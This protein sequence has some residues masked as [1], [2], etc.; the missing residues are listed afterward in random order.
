VEETREGAREEGIS[1]CGLAMEKSNIVVADSEVDMAGGD[2]GLLVVAGGIA[3]QLEH[4][5]GKIL[6]DGGEVDG[7]TCTNALGIFAIS[8]QTV[9]TADG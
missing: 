7:G 1:G 9:S 3:C 5:G 2:T 8:E 6:E 4:L